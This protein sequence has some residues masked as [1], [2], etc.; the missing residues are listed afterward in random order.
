MVLRTHRVHSPA[1]EMQGT[2]GLYHHV[3]SN[4]DMPEEQ[5]GLEQA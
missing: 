1:W 3:P 2:K 4:T 5:C